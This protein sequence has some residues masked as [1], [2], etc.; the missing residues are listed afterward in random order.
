VIFK[1]SW[2]HVRA[3]NTEPAIRVIA[4]ART[5]DEAKALIGSSLNV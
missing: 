5:M 2:V 4:E 3:S 1:D